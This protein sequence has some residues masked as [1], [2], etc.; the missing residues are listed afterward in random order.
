M[1]R[2]QT[3]TYHSLVDHRHDVSLEDFNVFT[4]VFVGFLY[5]KLDYKLRTTGY[6]NLIG[7]FSEAIVLV[8]E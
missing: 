1:N 2:E 8:Y 4:E 6:Q 7:Q 3:L 5:G